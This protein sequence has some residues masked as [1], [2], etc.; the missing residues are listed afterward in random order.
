[1]SSPT[2]AEKKRGLL[3]SDIVDSIRHGCTCKKVNHWMKIPSWSLEDYMFDISQ[4]ER[5][6]KK[7]SVLGVLTGCLR[8]SP[9]GGEERPY[10]F[11]YTVRGVVVCRNVF[12]EVHGVGTHVMKQ[13]QSKAEY[14]DVY[15]SPHGL[16]GKTPRHLSL[17]PDV[18]SGVVQFIHTYANIL[19]LPQ[20]AAERGHADIPPVY[21]PASHNKKRAFKAYLDTQRSGLLYRAFC[22]I[23]RTEAP[24]VKVMKPRTDVC[25]K[26]D[27]LRDK[28]RVSRTEEE[29]DSSVKALHLHVTAAQEERQYYRDMIESARESL[30]HETS[31]DG[32][33]H[34]T[35]DFA[36][37]LELPYQTR[38]VGPLML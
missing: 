8:K 31:E 13:L 16:S 17:D 22:R 4:R 12:M 34:Y 5:R 36:Q 24:H 6:K 27:K 15:L 2:P 29:T 7:M 21:L 3:A 20:P 25:A 28:I 11:S 32:I 35:F 30:D 10:F 9:T 14:G 38:K 37:Q 19:G 26:C 1:M 18:R 33:A 23:W